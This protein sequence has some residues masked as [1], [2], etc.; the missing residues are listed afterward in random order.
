MP[1]VKEPGDGLDAR[2]FG[3]QPL[4]AAVTVAVAA[5]R[6][7]AGEQAEHAGL[8]GLHVQTGA[9]RQTLAAVALAAE[10]RADQA[11]L[12]VLT[13]RPSPTP[14]PFLLPPARAGVT[15][16]AATTVA[17][18]RVVFMVILRVE[19]GGVPGTRENEEGCH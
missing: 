17:I 16:S 15:A 4:P 12:P 8:A 18:A 3:R 9:D 7:A 10:K 5:A 14:R 11:A 1:E 2:A 19:P 6:R 13:P